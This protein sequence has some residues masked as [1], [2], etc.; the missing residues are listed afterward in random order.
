DRLD[1]DEQFGRDLL[2][3]VAAGQQPQHLALAWRELVDLRVDGRRN[4]RVPEGVQDEAGKPRTE[5][6]VATRHAGDG[7]CELV[8]GDRLGDV[9]RGAGGDDRDD[10]LGGVETRRR[11]EARLGPRLT[12]LLEDG[13]PAAFG[14]VDVEK[15]DL[16]LRVRYDRDRF[17]NGP[18]LADDRY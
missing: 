1:G 4:R 14:H 5:H 16:G 13:Q 2:V 3:R 8:S 10:V 9:A 7:S 11:E 6:R 17:G 15:Y 18:R 12:H